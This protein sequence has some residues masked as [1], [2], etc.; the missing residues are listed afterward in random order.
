MKTATALRTAGLMVC[1]VLLA[2]SPQQNNKNKNETTEM[3]RGGKVKIG[4]VCRADIRQYCSSAEKG[5]ARRECLENNIDKLSS[6]CKTALEQRKK[7]RGGKFH[8]M[9]NNNNNNNN[10]DDND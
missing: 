5:K 3:T 6:D 9:Q 7:H 8:E 1:T 4:R 10:N 2:C